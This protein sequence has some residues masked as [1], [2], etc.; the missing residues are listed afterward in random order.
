MRADWQRVPRSWSGCA[1]ALVVACGGVL[2]SPLPAPTDGPAGGAPG[3]TS[4][5]GGSGSTT[6]GAG[7]TGQAVQTLGRTG[8]RRLSNSEYDN[9]VRD[10]LG[11]K[12][13]LA[14]AFVSEGAAGF[15]NVAG[16][17]GMTP[18]QYESY[19][20]A[21]ET[22]SAELFADD[23]RVVSTL[24]CRAAADD[25]G[26]CL[27]RVLG[28]FGTRAFRRPLVASD[29]EGLRKVYQSALAAGSSENQALAQVLTAVLASPQFLYRLELAQ[30]NDV[31]A[32]RALDGYELASRLS[33]FVW[34]SSPDTTLLQLAS[35]GELTRTEVL[36]AQ[37]KR[38]LGDARANTLVSN[39]AAQ[40]LDLRELA[41]H[42]VSADKYPGFDDALRRSMIEEAQRFFAEFLRTPR[43][44][45][46]FLSGS[47]HFVDSR[48]AALYGL[49]LKPG[50]TFQ[51]VDTP[52]GGRRGFLGLAAFLT[53]SSFSYR[54]SPTL[55]AKW[56]LEELL[57]S[58]VP[59]PPPNVAADLAGDD[60]ANAA[61]SIDN[62]RK[63]LELHRS[64]PSCAG[65]HASLDPIGLGLEGFDAIGKART[66][67]DNGDRVDTHGELPGGKV[68]DG[69]EQLASVLVNDARFPRCVAEKLLTYALGRSVEKEDDLIEDALAVEGAP[70][71]SGLIEN[72]VLSDMFRQQLAS[73]P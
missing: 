59:P 56:V 24:S 20:T 41:Q 29:K 52:I 33:Y 14:A 42:K 5:A 36:A 22:L 51:R 53:N 60:A 45:S 58:T 38:L 15:D 27:E 54:T 31:A 3:A 70:T 26:A 57:C 64:A 2:E 13:T 11:T 8:P 16:A 72:I 25:K 47:L 66:V 61:A 1:L 4:P 35:S 40:W 9:T 50:D 49:D 28:D 21:A 48:L 46:D 73:Q 10:L 32:S 44:L 63:R 62:V 37:L 68:F 19:Y 30:A 69:P 18:S 39:F 71:V 23:K 34:S 55:R 6:P 67:Y 17:L 65:C 43:P 12:Q 7:T